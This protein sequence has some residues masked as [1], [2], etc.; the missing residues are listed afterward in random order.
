[1]RSPLDMTRGE[2]GTSVR[3]VCLPFLC[4]FMYAEGGGWEDLNYQ[5]M[6]SL[7]WSDSIVVLNF[8]TA[9]SSANKAL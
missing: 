6:C 8:Q 1:M 3:L 4:E 9:S 2:Y 5:V 7:E